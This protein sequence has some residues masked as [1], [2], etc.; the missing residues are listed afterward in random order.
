MTTLKAIFL[1]ILAEILRPFL[2][3]SIDKDFEDKVKKN[4]DQLQKDIEELIR[5]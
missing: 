1:M 5:R 4:K 2:Q 3:K